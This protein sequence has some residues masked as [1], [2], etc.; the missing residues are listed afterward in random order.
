MAKDNFNNGDFYIKEIGRTTEDKL[1]FSTV[2]FNNGIWKEY[3]STDLLP[4]PKRNS[5][6]WGLKKD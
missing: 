5:Y 4:A 1:I 3:K 6:Y 2:I